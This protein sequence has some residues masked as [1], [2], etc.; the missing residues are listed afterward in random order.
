MKNLKAK[1]EAMEKYTKASNYLPVLFLDDEGDIDK[2]QHL[3]GPETVVFIDDY[4]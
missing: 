3:I 1:I 4:S 2:Y